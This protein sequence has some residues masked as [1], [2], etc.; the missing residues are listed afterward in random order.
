[1]KPSDFFHFFASLK[2][3][4]FSILGLAIVL[5]VGTVLESIYGTRAALS[6]VYGTWWFAGQLFLLGLNVTCAALSRYP[7]KKHQTGFVITH[8]GIITILLGSLL[9]QKFGV[10]GSLPVVQKQQSGKVILNDL[11]LY[12]TNEDTGVSE[13]FSIPETGRKAEGEILDIDFSKDHR[14]VVDRFY[15]RIS[16][17]EKLVPSVIAGVGRPAIKVNIFNSRMNIDEWLVHENPEVPTEL[18]LGPAI[19]RFEKMWSKAQETAFLK[20][21]EKWQEKKQPRIGYL[22]LHR[23]GREVR[24]PLEKV[25]SKWQSVASLDIELKLLR[26]LP[27]A[28]VKKNTLVNKTQAPVNPTL[29]LNVR[30]PSGQIEKH[31]I[32]AKFPEFPTLHRASTTNAVPGL[33]LSFISTDPKAKKLRPPPRG[34]LFLAQSYDNKKLYYRVMGRGGQVNDQGEITPGEVKA[35]GWM[36]LNFKVEEWIPFSNRIQEPRYIDKIATTETNFLSAIHVTSVR[37]DSS[38]GTASLNAIDQWLFEG[39]PAMVNEG[40]R[41]YVLRY[42]KERLDLP[43]AIFLEKFKVGYDPGTKKAATYESNVIVKETD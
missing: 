31:T 28:V 26:Y 7:W 9:T 15:P 23:G 16:T 21:P 24:V 29:Q 41:R 5:A 37:K 6:M 14:L 38:R 33:K 34:Q 35:T 43:F 2:L 42:G 27:Y 13:K 39:Q 19:I 22:I 8:V 1:M 36:D 17:E 3:A 18:S 12:I 32:F 25:N 30:A 40:G 20:R 4:V 11:Y 10:D